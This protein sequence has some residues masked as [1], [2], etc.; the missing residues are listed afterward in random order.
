MAGSAGN[1]TCFDGDG[2]WE[3]CVEIEILNG[4]SER[5]GNL[6][7][8]NSSGCRRKGVLEQIARRAMKQYGFLSTTTMPSTMAKVWIRD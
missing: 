5:S 2:D 8:G 6:W 3:L 1:R 7:Y 4:L